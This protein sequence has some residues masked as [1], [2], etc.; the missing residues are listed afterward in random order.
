MD[1]KWF[2]VRVLAGALEGQWLRRHAHAHPPQAQTDFIPGAGLDR[3]VALAADWIS[4]GGRVL[5]DRDEEVPGGEG[6]PLWKGKAC[7][8]PERWQL[9]KQRFGEIA[10]NESIVEQTR[11]LARGAKQTMEE[12]E[13]GRKKAQ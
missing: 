4:Y 7:L 2:G 3:S 6:G 9:W 10:D 8:C 12:I 5:F 13:E 1:I 11:Q